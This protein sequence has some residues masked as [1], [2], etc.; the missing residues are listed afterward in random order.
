MS[1]QKPETKPI[2]FRIPVADYDRIAVLAERDDR[3]IS[4]YI[5]Q[6]LKAEI[7]NAGANTNSQ[8]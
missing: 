4:S 3:S 6:V 2:Q 7:S 8:T 5:R 1:K